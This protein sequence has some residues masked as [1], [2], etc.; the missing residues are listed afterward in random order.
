MVLSLKS[1]VTPRSIL[2]LKSSPILIGRM[3]YLVGSQEMSPN[4]LRKA[5]YSSNTLGYMDALHTSISLSFV[6]YFFWSDSLRLSKSS[7][8]M[9]A[10]GRP[11]TVFLPLSTWVRSG[12]GKP[13]GGWPR[14][15]WKYSTTEVGKE[16]VAA[17][18][19]R[20]CCSS[21]F[22]TMNCARS[23]TTFEVG[24]TLMMSPRRR[25]AVAYAFLIFIHWSARPS[26][27]AW[28]IRFVICPPGISCRYT[29]AFPVFWFASNGAYSSRHFSQ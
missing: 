28:N 29:S 25:L 21:S 27:D 4:C 5:A 10:P 23:P 12:S 8:G 20:E 22:C 24:V 18:S 26:D 1:R 3:K 17:L 2:K 14:R 19:S 16:R 11:S 13:P 15:P 9:D 6:P 7:G